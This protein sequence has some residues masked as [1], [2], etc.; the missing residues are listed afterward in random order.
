MSKTVGTML[1]RLI[2]YSLLHNGSRWLGFWAKF[3]AQITS[4]SILVPRLL[5]LYC[6][7]LL[8]IF[9]S[10]ML[11]RFPVTRALA[12]NHVT[13]GGTAYVY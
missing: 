13:D 8:Y 3:V 9:R 2:F 1:A 10:S 7:F 5:M 11:G 12:R 4:T 6:K